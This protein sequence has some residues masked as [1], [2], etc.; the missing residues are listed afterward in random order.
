M[1]AEF[2]YIETTFRSPERN[3]TTNPNRP[4]PAPIR[5]PFPVRIPSFSIPPKCPTSFPTFPRISS[6]RLSVSEPLSRERNEPPPAEAFDGR[7]PKE[8]GLWRFF[9]YRQDEKKAG[10]DIMVTAGGHYLKDL[11]L[12][13]GFYRQQ[14]L[15]PRQGQEERWCSVL[16]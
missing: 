7:D 4:I 8:G 15:L 14:Q 5:H 12:N 1:C 6:G 3:V 2:E 11:F 10:L 16:P 9:L 13:I